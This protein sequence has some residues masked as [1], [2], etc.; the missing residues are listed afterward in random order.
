MVTDQQVRRLIKLM[1]N[2]ATKSLAAAKAGMTRKTAAKY[3]RLNEIPSHLKKPHSWRTRQDP[4][5]EIWGGIE[6]ML[7]VN[8]ALE[9]TP[10]FGHLQR[11]HPGRFP[12]GQLRTLQRRMRSWRAIK[13]P[14]KEVFFPQVHTPGDLSESDFTHMTAL[15]ITIRGVLF[16]HLLYHF[17]L[18][19]SNWETGTI[20]FSESFEALAEGYQNAVWELGYVPKKHRTDRMTAAVNKECN[21]DKFT[22]AYSA[23][24]R[25]YN[26]QPER[27]NPA[28]ANENGDIEQRH[29]RLKRSLSQALMIRGSADFAS[30]EDYVVFLRG[31]FNQV[32]SNRREKQREELSRSGKLPA[33]RLNAYKTIDVSVDQSS[34]IHVQKNTYSV[35]SRL[36][37]ERVRVKIFTGRL[38]LVY[39]QITV[40]CI[41]RLKG[42]GKHHINYRHIIEWLVRKPGAFK[43]YRYQAEMFPSSYFRMAYDDLK[44]RFPMTADK[45]Y[46]RILHI[47]A[48]DGET[49]TEA[50]IRCLLAG[51]SAIAVKAI[52]KIV[53]DQGTPAP[54]TD[55]VIDNVDLAQYDTLLM[56]SELEVCVHG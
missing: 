9:A 10:L 30:R 47:A 1:Q 16:E 54:I 11:T 50:A 56:P 7:E 13:G 37:G 21:P 6:A 19:Y 14:A 45:E 52:R 2:K 27:T 55:V 12:D 4:F 3:L 31:I 20:C 23:L 49:V 38:E 39:G 43:N 24:L 34:T 35:H 28:S 29:Y 40:D 18:T 22:R 36:I 5:E 26:T 17:V 15:G 53:S 32:N 51:E 41:P 44:S 48:Q 46:V 8:P 42:S 25:H 33:R